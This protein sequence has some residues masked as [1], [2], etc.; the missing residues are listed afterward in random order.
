MFRS[1]APFSFRRAT[2]PPRSLLALAALGIAL[3]ACGS[4]SGGDPP[5]R[6]AAA[7]AGG[8]GSGGASASST[9]PAT[10]DPTDA[11]CVTS[12]PLGREPVRCDTADPCPLGYELSL[13]CGA[14][15]SAPS[16]CTGIVARSGAFCAKSCPATAPST[17]DGGTPR[18]GD[19]WKLLSS[20]AT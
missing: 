3:G 7:V 16:A 11:I 15:D 20:C 14:S 1:L 6:S 19:G 4:D 2:R 10:C 5:A 17:C 13:A 8:A 12:C 9:G 18:C